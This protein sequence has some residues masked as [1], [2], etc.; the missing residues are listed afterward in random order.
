MTDNPQDDKDLQLLDQRLRE[1]NSQIETFELPAQHW[2]KTFA[3]SLMMGQEGRPSNAFNDK[4]EGL[5]AQAGGD[6]HAPYGQ[7]GFAASFPTEEKRMEFLHAF[8]AAARDE[9][10]ERNGIRKSH[11][12][13]KLGAYG[14]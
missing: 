6:I 10:P 11:N 7:I 9:L 13:W 4:V 1:W 5:V 3:V 14:I 12:G 2:R 8:A